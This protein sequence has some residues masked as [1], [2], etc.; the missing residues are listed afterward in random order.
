MPFGNDDEDGEDRFSAA[1]RSAAAGQPAATAPSDYEHEYADLT[2]EVQPFNYYHKRYP[3]IPNYHAQI[4]IFTMR[5]MH[6]GG[7]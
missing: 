3:P 2:E 7:W 6:S 4:L 1:R 5:H